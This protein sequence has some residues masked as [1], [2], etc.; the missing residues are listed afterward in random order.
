[1]GLAVIT[2]IGQ[3]VGLG[4]EEQIRL[5]TKKLM[6]LTYLMSAIWNAI[7][8]ATLPL[9]LRMYN[10]SPDAYSL[11]LKLIIIHNGCAI[12]IWPASFTM[13]NVLKAANDVKFTMCIA[14]FSMFTFRL[15][16]S[17][18]IGLKLGMG[19]IGVW[20][21]MIVDWVFRAVAFCLRYRGKRWLSYSIYKKTRNRQKQNKF[22][23]A[24][25]FTAGSDY[26]TA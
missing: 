25:V 17:Y 16:L 22:D 26:I 9:T 2:V 21:A 6:K 3:C 11:A 14:L 15:L 20:I 23:P 5:H 24:V 4:S 18:I 7:I 13:P 10:I 8:L 1:M 19:A 12:F